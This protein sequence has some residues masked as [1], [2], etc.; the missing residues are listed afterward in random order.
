MAEMVGHFFGRVLILFLIGKVI[1][2]I[3][4]YHT[5]LVI[6]R[7]LRLWFTSLDAL[8]SLIIWFIIRGDIRIYVTYFP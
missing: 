8:Y 2:G 7:N 4:A 5:H 3:S 1:T 6:A